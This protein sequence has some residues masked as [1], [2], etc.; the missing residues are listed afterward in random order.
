MHFLTLGLWL[1]HKRSRCHGEA[2]VIHSEAFCEAKLGVK[3]NIS[4]VCACRRKFRT[5]GMDC[6]VQCAK[7][8]SSFFEDHTLWL[9]VAAIAAAEASITRK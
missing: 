1:G 8:E 3:A 7:Q 4:A 6:P 2:L 5:V 9:V